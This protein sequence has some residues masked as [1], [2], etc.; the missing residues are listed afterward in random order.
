VLRSFRLQRTCPTAR[1]MLLVV[2]TAVPA[3]LLFHPLY[4]W[5]DVRFLLPLLPF[6]AALAG[7]GAEW[8]RAALARAFGPERRA[9][10]AAGAVTVVLGVATHLGAAS[11]AR[12]F[13]EQR[14][15][16]PPPLTAELAALDRS[17]PRP[18]T[19]I[20]NFPITL[21]APGLGL[22]RTLIV[23]D[24]QTSDAHLNQIANANLAGLDGSRPAVPALARGKLLEHATLDAVR[25]A[26]R[27]GRDVFYLECDGEG[28]P[29]AGVAAL[30]G[31]L[32]FEEAFVRR[33]VTVYRLR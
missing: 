27:A 23:A 21:A 24:L 8:L 32:T 18:A 7:G 33:P 10:A 3:G 29:G 26:V 19:L 22:D 6:V 13:D 30:R 5:Q 31:E 12:A 28:A 11:F 1:T 17:L 20:V 9:L 16:L 14:A 25:A 4:V 2:S 15:F